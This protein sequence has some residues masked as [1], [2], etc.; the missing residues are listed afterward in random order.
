MIAVLCQGQ[1]RGQLGRKAARCRDAAE[2]AFKARDFFFERSN[3]RIPDSR[4]DVAVRAQREELGRVFGRIEH[5]ARGEIDGLRARAGR[6]IG[7][8]SRVERTRPHPEAAIVSFACHRSQPA[9]F[10]FLRCWPVKFSG[11][12]VVE[13][14]TAWPTMS[15]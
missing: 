3:R 5:E 10:D 8:R 12:I 2:R 14:E 6:R 7:R 4:V 15:I 9:I 11:L 1:D 13:S